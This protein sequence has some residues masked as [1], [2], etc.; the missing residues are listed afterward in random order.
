MVIAD[1][2]L[3][4]FGKTYCHHDNVPFPLTEEVVGKM[5]V[6]RICLYFTDH[7]LH[8]F[9]FNGLIIRKIH[10]VIVNFINSFESRASISITKLPKLTLFFLNILSEIRCQILSTQIMCWILISI[11]LNVI[12]F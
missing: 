4:N 5:F 6:L 9:H 7:W 8:L 2:N 11:T 1:S 3:E 12:K 10:K